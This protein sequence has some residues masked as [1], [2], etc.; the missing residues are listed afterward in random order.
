[1]IRDRRRV[2]AGRAGPKVSSRRFVRLLRA[3]CKEVG[4]TV[5]G[6]AVLGLQLAQEDGRWKVAL[7]T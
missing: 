2:G 6:R 1:M 7:E 3:A 4:L 5:D